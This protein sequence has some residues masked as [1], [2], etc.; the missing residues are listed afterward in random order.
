[1]KTE[2]CGFCICRKIGIL[3]KKFVPEFHLYLMRHA[4]A[5]FSIVDIS[6]K[7]G[8]THLILASTQS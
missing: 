7:N 8:P 6:P 3:I 1:V 4:I 5:Y 2:G